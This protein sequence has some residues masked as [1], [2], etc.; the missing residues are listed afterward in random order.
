MEIVFVLGNIVPSVVIIDDTSVVVDTVP[1]ITDSEIVVVL[2]DI[3]PSVVTDGC[4]SSSF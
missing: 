3:V 1:V 4:N 2:G